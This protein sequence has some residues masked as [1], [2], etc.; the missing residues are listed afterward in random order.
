VGLILRE[1][2]KGTP[3]KRKEVKRDKR[4]VAILFVISAGVVFF[5]YLIT[6]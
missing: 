4:D 5:G 1:K 2:K 6:R 3:P